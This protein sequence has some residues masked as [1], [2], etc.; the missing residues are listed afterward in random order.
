MFWRKKSKSARPTRG[1]RL[2]AYGLIL[3]GIGAGIWAGFLWHNQAGETVPPPLPQ[4]LAPQESATPAPVAKPEPKVVAAYQ[5]A[6]TLPKFI[7]IPAIGVGKTRI[8]SLGLTSDGHIAVPSSSYDTGWYTGSA[9]PGDSGA[10]FIY[11]HVA[12]WNT[13]GIFYNLK[14]LKP[15]DN[16]IVTRGD[17]TTYTYTVDSLKLYPVK[18]VDMNAVLAP[19]D[20]TKP[21][22]NL[23]TCTWDIVGGK[24]EFNNR[25]VVFASLTS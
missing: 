1:V 2:I 3:V 19:I 16:I 10:M 24:S 15:G 18:D 13:G 17:D 25:Q 5:V 23:M 7:S 20:P 12:G 11:G 9:K 8:L 14:K 6:P 21:G 4:M 22:L